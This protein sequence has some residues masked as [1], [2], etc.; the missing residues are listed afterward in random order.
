M[1]SNKILNGKFTFKKLPNGSIDKTKVICGFCGCELSYH[2]STSSLK[3][4]LMAKHTADGNSPL[5]GQSQATMDVF[6]QKH[7]DTTTKNKLTA[8]IAKWVATACRPVNVVEDEGLADIIRIASNDWTYEL[9]S[10]ATITSNVQKLYETEKAKVQQALDN[11]KAVALTGDYWTSVSNHNYLGVTAHY[12]DPQWKLQSHALTVLKT[13]ERHFADAVAEHFM[14]VA[15]EWDIEQKVVSLTTDSARNMIAAARQLPFVHVPCIAHSVHR[16]VTVS[17]TNSPFDSA[18]A[19]CRKVVGH[20]KHSPANQAELEQQQVTHNKKKES[21]AQEVSTRWNSTLEMIKRVQRNAEPLKDALALHT[22]NIA[23]PTVTELEKLKKLEAVLEHCRYVSELLGG[24]KFV[25]C[26]VVLPALCHLS[27][28][29]EVTEDDPAY[30]IKFKGTFAADME[31]RKEKT[32][33]TWLRVATALDPRFKDLKCLSKP[34]RAE[35][36][37]TIRALLQEMVRERPAQPD[38][39]VTPEPPTKKPTLM[40]TNE[41]S[42]DEEEDSIDQCL[43]RYKSEPLTGMDDCPQE[44]WSTHE[45]AHSEMARLARK[46]LAT[47]ATSVPS[48][49]LFSLSG[50]VVQKKR[51]SLLSE[52]V[53]RLVCLSNWLKAKK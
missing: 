29:M 12:F 22:T 46:Y 13:E 16:A 35:V 6:R 53:N 18:L 28:V 5:P 51:A 47:P 17:L 49:R 14:Q 27:R 45:G 32:N 2:R 8:A 15:R 26:S 25:S 48:E 7:M 50:H 19:K 24:E 30:T 11:T 33:I 39:K 20:F 42:S 4:H 37:G 44:W 40:L 31:G 9:P 3:Y 38:N 34:D 36:W 23:M 52:N 41:S 21:L 43:R 1:D 10:R